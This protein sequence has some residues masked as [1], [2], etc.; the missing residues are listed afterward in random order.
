MALLQELGES[1]EKKGK[2]ET[3]L[4]GGKT[5]C[6]AFFHLPPPLRCLLSTSL[7]F[8]QQ[9]PMESDTVNKPPAG[10]AFGLAQAAG[11]H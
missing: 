11:S 8:P 5:L 7:P 3:G 10:S 4:C 6:S 1:L 2:G 9:V